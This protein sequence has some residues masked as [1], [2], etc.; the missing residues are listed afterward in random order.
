MTDHV[1]PSR[2]WQVLLIGGASGTGKTSV[3]YRLARHF[4]VGITEVD[5][6][7]VMLE[8]MTTPEQQP[9]LHFWKTHP[10]APRLPAEQ[11]MAQG[12]DVRRVM[13]P[14]LAAVIANHLES[15]TPIVL[16][17]DFIHPE[18]AARNDFYEQTND[19]RVRGVFLYEP[20]EEQLRR[21]FLQREPEAGVQ[22]KRARVSWLFGEWLRR[23]SAR[24]GIT[25][26]PARPWE[27]LFERILTAI[28]PVTHTD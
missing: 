22:E 13:A 24:L 16:E 8:R 18:L 15:R 25:A 11:I 9:V 20:D 3:S 28:G 4:D 6:F 17:G 26:L 7:Q 21:N 10:D 14:A 1:P 2:S 5:D 27:T 12:L 19:G 23:E